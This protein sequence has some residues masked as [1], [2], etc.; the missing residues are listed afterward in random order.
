MTANPSSRKK[1]AR[2]KQTETGVPR[3]RSPKNRSDSRHNSSQLQSSWHWTCGPDLRITTVSKAF[4]AETGLNPAALVGKTFDEVAVNGVPAS[5]ASESDRK[6]QLS[7]FKRHQEFSD[8]VYALNGVSDRIRY[9]SV[10]GEPKF[11]QRGKFMG[12]E[13]TGVD[14]TDS[15]HA[16]AAAIAE[17]VPL[18]SVIDSLGDGLALWDADN[19][20]VLCNQIFKS[21][22][23]PSTQ[24]ARPGTP[25]TALTSALVAQTMESDL[26]PMNKW[27]TSDSKTHKRRESRH[28]IRRTDGHWILIRNRRTDNGYTV[29]QFADITDRKRVER[30]FAKR[31]RQQAVVAELGRAALTEFDFDRLLQRATRMIAETLNVEFVS[32]REL[33]SP[34]DKLLLRAGYG[35]KKELVGNWT[36]DLDRPIVDRD[37]KKT[38][39]AQTLDDAK[40]Q[41][42][43]AS[44]KVLREHGIVSGMGVRIAGRETPFGILDVHST[45]SRNITPDEINFLESV[46]YVL[47][48][49][50]ERMHI[51]EDLRQSERRYDLAIQGS[52][53]GLWDWDLVT[54]EVYFSPR[55]LEMLGL[56]E[57]DFQ[58]SVA[59]WMERLH[60][61]DREIFDTHL[62]SHLSGRTQ[63]FSVECR[64]LHQDGAYRW[65]LVRGL[66]VREKNKAVRIAGS[67]SDITENK[68]AEHRLLKDALHDTLTALPNR[69]LFTDRV[70]QA[71]VRCERH[72]DYLFAVLFLDLDRFKVINDSLGHSYGDQVLIEMATRLKDCI[73][74]VDTVARL[75]GDEFAIL[76]EDLDS[77]E[78]AE[79]VARRINYSLAQPFRLASREIVSNVSIG[80][81]FSS[82][83]YDRPDEMIRDAD[84][85]MYQA[86][87]QGRSRH[88]VFE[89][90]MH[91]RAVTQLETETDLRRA[92]E[93]NE[94]TLHYQPVV[95]IR[96]G[97][98]D[99]FEALVRWRHPKRG[100]VPPSDF[101]TIAEETGLIVP[102]GRLILREACGQMQKWAKKYP[103]SR[104][105]ISV[106]I[107]P[108]QFADPNFLDDVRQVLSQTGLSGRRLS[109][110]ITE[111]AIMEN[112]HEV[113]MRLMEL[114]KLGIDLHVDDFGTGYSS[115]SHLHRFP[116]DALKVDRSFVITMGESNENLEI[117]RTIIVLAHNLKLKTVAEG[118]ETKKDLDQLKKLKCDFAQGYFFSRPMT[119]KKASDYLTRE[120]KLNKNK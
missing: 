21:E 69:A 101:I 71:I 48:V 64:L 73:R 113:T 83:G 98:L 89:K 82:L 79:L 4:S 58:P 103:R 96:N 60:A 106:N 70:A 45:T 15:I 85:A 84:I 6:R 108:K 78:M 119:S 53:D 8:L 11:G 43:D 26:E 27:V 7:A 114:R 31:E 65:M 74:E 93:R 56:S 59:N 32:V 111:G 24:L 99:G 17:S 62:K 46:A 105:G 16:D 107:S 80:V 104:F 51:I 12:Y 100:F 115:L 36:V 75:G 50:V 29:S 55:W 110:E 67:M 18:T 42:Q 102:I 44:A 13:G 1:T 49:A 35:W 97:K 117:V 116:I 38:G 88:V 47:G 33:L 40:Q 86:K 22:F 34:G 63:N 52:K 112:P 76:L 20:L 109:I 57:K 39:A 61:D 37:K 41:A 2:G 72:P 81:A 118:V 14:V 92:I 9:V 90:G 120:F 10:S 28:E 95:S 66:A 54:D 5:I 19:R 94:F 23:A 77:E 91:L 87:T 3:A 68:R 30:N 25:L